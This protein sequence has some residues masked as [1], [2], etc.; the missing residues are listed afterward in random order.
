MQKYILYIIIW[1]GGGVPCLNKRI[2]WPGEWWFVGKGGNGIRFDYI[3]SLMQI[4][5]RINLASRSATY[6]I[7]YLLSF[8]ANSYHLCPLYSS[9]FVVRTF[10][11]I[12]F[13][14]CSFILL[15]F[16]V[17]FAGFFHPIF[18]LFLLIYPHLYFCLFKLVITFLSSS[19]SS[20]ALQRKSH[21]C[22]SF[23]RI[24]RPQSPFPH[25]CVCERFIYFQVRSTYF[26]AAE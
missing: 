21:F 6:V 8:P 19:S 3:S 2:S 24:A 22:I 11:F 10:I 5:T 26:P 7:Q 25:S 1:K 12:L 23:L 20:P 15:T 16:F 4:Y 17:V 9:S 13:S 18:V 14:T